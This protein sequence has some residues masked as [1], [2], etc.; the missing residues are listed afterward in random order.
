MYRHRTHP[1]SAT[2]LVGPAVHDR[3]SMLGSSFRAG[4]RTGVQ[5]DF[6]IEHNCYWNPK[7]FLTQTW[8]NCRLIPSVITKRKDQA[9]WKSPNIHAEHRKR[10]KNSQFSS[11]KN[12]S[13]YNPA[14]APMRLIK[15]SLFIPSYAKPCLSCGHL[16]VTATRS[17]RCQVW[18]PFPE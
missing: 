14:N 10:E 13:R 1:S 5:C 15:K 18:G 8:E 16:E 4:V 17:N 6:A 9:E 2:S 11:N 12:H 3:G 7:H